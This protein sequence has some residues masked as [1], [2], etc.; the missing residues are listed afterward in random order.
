MSEAKEQMLLIERCRVTDWKRREAGLPELGVGR[1]FHV[2]NG[3]LRTKSEAAKLKAM[4]VVAGVAD[5]FLPVPKV[6]VPFGHDDRWPGVLISDSSER[7]IASVCC[8][9]WIEMKDPGSGKVK[10]SGGSR[11]KE[12]EA[13][14]KWGYEIRNA[15]YAWAACWGVDEAWKVICDYLGV[16]NDQIL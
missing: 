7:E 2:P 14:I 9:L 10:S 4:G 16:T 1:I 6:M 8:G 13:Q 5:L 11:G 3:G 15:G 12:S